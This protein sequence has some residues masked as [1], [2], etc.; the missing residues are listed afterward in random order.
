MLGNAATAGWQW[1][2]TIWIMRLFGPKELGQY[3]YILAVVS[4]LL[5]FS[6][7]QL[8]NRLAAQPQLLSKVRA[9][10]KLRALT[11]TVSG[12]VAGLWIFWAGKHIDP[13]FVGAIL[14]FKAVESGS[15]LFQ[16]VLHADGQL[17]RVGA[18]L[19]LKAMIAVVLMAICYQSNLSVWLFFV[20]LAGAHVVVMYLIEWRGSSRFSA[21]PP[22]NESV[23]QVFSGDPFLLSL[24]TTAWLT[25]INSSWPRYFIE[26]SHGWAKLGE[27]SAIFA[28]YAVLSVMLNAWLQS[29]LGVLSSASDN[30]LV[31][32]RKLSGQ[33]LLYHLL[34]A[35]V[36]GWLGEKFLEVMFARVIPFS[37]AEALLLVTLSMAAGLSTLFYY[38][39]LACSQ[40]K[41]HWAVMLVSN[42]LTLITAAWLIPQSI[43]SGAL[44]SLL[45]GTL[46]QLACFVLM[47]R[48]LLREG[49]SRVQ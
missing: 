49:S 27:F 6:N 38:F 28:L 35:L 22:V 40:M 8:R 7:F 43:I 14:L 44:A 30:R 37:S 47:I 36:L 13:W 33:I 25:S 39:L 42:G 26:T 48:S 20:V 41:R 10:L 46:W 2:L 45:V 23:W 9:F 19:V 12:M 21:A 24:G 34:A 5:L 4:P 1:L 17:P 15:E 11:V 18:S 16:G 32:L 31:I 29:A 3:S